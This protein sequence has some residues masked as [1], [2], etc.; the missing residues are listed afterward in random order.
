MAAS[1]LG[2]ALVESIL[3]SE[4]YWM[5][6]SENETQVIAGVL[7]EL[8]NGIAVIGIA[9][10]L[11]PVLS[12]RNQNIALGYLGFRVVE[13]VFCSIIVISPLSLIALSQEYTSAGTALAAAFSSAGAL[14]IAARASVAGLLIPVFF[15]LGALL[16]YVLAYQTW[17][18]PRPL[19]AWGLIGAVL[20]LTNTLLVTFN[21]ELSMGVQMIFVLPM[22]LNEIFLGIWL[23]VKGFNTQAAS[24]GLAWQT[25]TL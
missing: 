1:L 13:A 19:A 17:L 18:L 10:M 16:F 23:M 25:S 9:V 14:S 3:S 8:L 22:I 7:L 15:S 6:V 12:R 11:Y 4:R 20:I 2:G 21:V 5:V 24:V